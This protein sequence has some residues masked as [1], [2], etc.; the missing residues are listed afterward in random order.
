MIPES[1]RLQGSHVRF[2]PCLAE[3]CAPN[4]ILERII[5]AFGEVD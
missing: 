3:K 4:P 5:E 2:V 1:E